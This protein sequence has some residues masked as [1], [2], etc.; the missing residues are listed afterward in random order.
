MLLASSQ[1]N[2]TKPFLKWPGGKR[3][4]TRRIVGLLDGCRFQRYFE[5]FLGG[6][7][8]FFALQ[9][10][11]AVLSD[12][13]ADLIN[14]YTQVKYRPLKV[15]ASLKKL[16]VKEATYKKVRIYN[17]ETKLE[18]AVRLLYLNRTGFGGMY[19][20]NQNG[21]FNVPFGGGERTPT[22]LWQ[23]HLLTSASRSLRHT[24]LVC[25]DFEDQLTEANTGDLVYCDPTY[26]VTHDNNGFV[27]YNERN[28][29]WAD[30]IRLAVACRSAARRG[31]TV[32]VSN[33]AHDKVLELY[34]SCEVHEFDRMSVLC[35]NS[36]KRRPTKEL[37]V[38]IRP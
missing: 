4:L 21:D 36:E 16:R 28:F 15:I 12:I 23:D 9:P 37:L 31:A 25:S 22:T 13:N 34:R 6:G 32:L 10:P 19:R 27:R 38:V 26:T 35:P 30:Q 8:L 24:E 17:P 20:L 3:W 7:A 14:T 33:A 5:P 2:Y 1:V 11:N 18:R 29:S